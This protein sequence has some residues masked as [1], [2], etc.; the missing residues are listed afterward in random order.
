MEARVQEPHVRS[1]E[2]PV[3]ARPGDRVRLGRQDFGAPDWIRMTHEQTGQTGWM[4]ILFLDGCDLKDRAMCNRD[5]AA[6]E[7]TVE[8][9]QFLQVLEA[10]AGWTWCRGM[11]GKGRLG[12]D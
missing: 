2:N 11:D 8:T 3:L 5:D 4:P 10:I 6:T 1:Y 12:P 7:L 9:G